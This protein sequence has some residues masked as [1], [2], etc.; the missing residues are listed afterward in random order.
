MAPALDIPRITWAIG[1]GLRIFVGAF[2]SRA[3]PKE[4][5]PEEQD[6]VWQRAILDTVFRLL[7]PVGT[8]GFGA[9]WHFLVGW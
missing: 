1:V 8:I 2:E 7:M 5:S 4:P 3:L 9:A 6:E